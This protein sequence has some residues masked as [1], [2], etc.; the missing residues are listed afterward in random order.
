MKTIL[1]GWIEGFVPKVR[2]YINDEDVLVL[3]EVNQLEFTVDTGFSAGISL[4]EELLDTM[5][6]EPMGLRAL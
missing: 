4:P 5:D 1:A 3:K 6:I 2:E